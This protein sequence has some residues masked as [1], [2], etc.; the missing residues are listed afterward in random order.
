MSKKCSQH[1][2]KF[3][4]DA[5]EAGLEWTFR[6]ELQQPSTSVESSPEAPPLSAPPE[7]QRS[8]GA[9]TLFL[10]RRDVNIGTIGNVNHTVTT[11]SPPPLIQT[12]PGHS[13]ASLSPAPVSSFPQEQCPYAPP[14]VPTRPGH[15]HASPRVLSPLPVSSFPHE[16]VETPFWIVFIFGN[17]SRCN[18]CK[19]R[20]S[21]SVDN[22]VLPPPDDIVLGHKEYV[23][24]QNSRS[25]LFEQSKDKRN[26]Y[27]HPWKTCIAPHFM[28]FDPDRHIVIQGLS[29]F[30]SIKIF[31]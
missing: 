28:D 15:T 1:I 29:Y 23:V 22:K 17:I 4:T 24:Y 7:Q 19:G 2:K 16:H 12:K 9:T 18:G 11:S 6:G 3:V 30:L 27:Y 5:E 21:R 13:H 31:F 10:S 8:S 25:G 20:I 26:V 14:L